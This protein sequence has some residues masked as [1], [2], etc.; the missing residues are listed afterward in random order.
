MPLPLLAW[1]GISATT[2][3]IGAT[4]GYSSRNSEVDRLKV[5]IRTLQSENQRLRAVI[6]EQ[7]EQI[8]IL[9]KKYESVHKLNFLNK[10]KYARQLNEAYIESYMRKEQLEVVCKKAAGELSA[11]EERFFELVMQTKRNEEEVL[12]IMGYITD[13]YGD[14]INK[15]NYPEMALNIAVDNINRLSV[16]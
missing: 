8:Q 3:L 1:I 9:W 15:R 6:K 10:H 2:A 16:D 7:Q 13:K 12:E 5:V 14:E 4:I 11:K